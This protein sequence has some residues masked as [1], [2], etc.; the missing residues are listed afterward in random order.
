MPVHNAANPGVAEGDAPVA[1][2]L[3]RATLGINIFLHGASR[4]LAGAGKFAA[5][6]AQQFH[7]APLP[8]PVVLGFAYALPCAEAAIGTLVLLG[9]FSRVALRRGRD[10]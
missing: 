9:L 10:S 5:Q 1:Y 4:I 3:L 7:A 2:L 8:E 6:L